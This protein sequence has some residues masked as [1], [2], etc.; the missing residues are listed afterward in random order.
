MSNSM[1]EAMAAGIPVLSTPVSGAGDALAPL[2]DGCRPG[3]VL[4]GYGEGELVDTLRVLLADPG[5]LRAM[6]EAAEKRVQAEFDFDLML[7]RWETVL[8]LP[9]P[10]A[11][12][13]APLP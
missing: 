11:A 7:D 4:A 3:V 1:L 8:N 5:G 10:G 12:P 9:T 13:V 6:G 2:S